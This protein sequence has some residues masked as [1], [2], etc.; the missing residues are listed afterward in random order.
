MNFKFFI[1][2][3][4]LLSL[5]FTQS[6]LI[7]IYIESLCPDCTGFISTSFKEFYNLNITNLASIEIIPFGNAN[8]TYNETTQLYE[9]SCQH[10]ENECYGN[11]IETCAINM[12]GKYL[13]GSLLICI[14]ENILQMDKN[15]SKVLDY[16]LDDK[17]MMNQLLTCAQSKTGNTWE[18]Y[19]AQK[20]ESHQY[21][22]WILVDGIHDVEI[23]NRI[24]NNMTDYLC[25]LPGKSCEK[26]LR[27]YD[28]NLPY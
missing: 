10:G 5:I 18:H 13:S 22:P 12:I 8:E 4:F 21:V 2:S 1:F 23:E 7:T 24:L 28:G 15:F 14:E 25:N 17:E 27:Y 20:T 3:S 9:F 6:P 16:C 19:M 26:R 11:I